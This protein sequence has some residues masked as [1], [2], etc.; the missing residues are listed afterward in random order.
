MSKKGFTLIEL[1]VVIAIIGIL[2]AI[3]LPALARAREAARRA[4]CANNLKQFGLVFKMYANESKGEKWPPAMHQGATP[5]SDGMLT[6]PNLPMIYPEYLADHNIFVCPS[7]TRVTEDD[8]TND[9]GQSILDVDWD[10]D[11]YA[12]P[13]SAHWWPAMFAYNYFGWAFDQS[14]SNETWSLPVSAVIGGFPA[15]V[16]A[17]VPASLDSELI[18]MQILAWHAINALTP[19]PDVTSSNMGAIM[20]IIDEDMDLDYTSMGGPASNPLYRLREGIERFLITDINNPAGSAM[21]QSEVAVMW[22]AIALIPSNFN[23]V[24]GG[25]NVLYMDGHVQFIRYPSDEMPVNAG[26]AL[27]GVVASQ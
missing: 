8:M 4:S 10:G 23:H 26:F 25:S 12:D 11:G 22:D 27:M 24:P 9:A 3:L 7:G 20:D 19:E 17:L 14:D 6:S 16:A 1:L 21:A 2:A 18:P 15:W 13:G 5:C